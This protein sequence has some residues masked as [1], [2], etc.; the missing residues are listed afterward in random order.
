VIL[1][2]KARVKLGEVGVTVR[3]KVAQAKGSF[4]IVS[5]D[6]DLRV[7]ILD[8]EDLERAETCFE[9]L[10]ELS[11]VAPSIM[12]GIPINFSHTLKHI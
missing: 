4:K 2:R 9:V 3:G 6:V 7:S 8:E 1:A 10:R 12:N 5:A 11:I